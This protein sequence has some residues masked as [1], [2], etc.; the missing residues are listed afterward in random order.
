MIGDITCRNRSN[1]FLQLHSYD[2]HRFLMI[3]II[4]IHKVSYAEIKMNTTKI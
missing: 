1:V 3:H 4:Y 2:T